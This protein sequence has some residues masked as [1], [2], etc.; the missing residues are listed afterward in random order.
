MQHGLSHMSGWHSDDRWPS[1]WFVSGPM[2]SISE[3][4]QGTSG[5]VLGH[6]MLIH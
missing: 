5:W 3:V 2:N 1:L 4:P 6:G